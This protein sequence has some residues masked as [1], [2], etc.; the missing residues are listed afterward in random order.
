MYFDIFRK[1]L[2]LFCGIALFALAVTIMIKANMGLSP[3]D[4]FHQG[5]S[6]KLNITF[7][8]A[9]ILVGLGIVIVNAILGERIGWGTICS[10]YFVGRGVDILMPLEVIPQ[11]TSILSGLVMLSVGMILLG[12]GS[13]FYLSA[14]LGSGPREGLMIALIKRTNKSVVAIRTI[15]EV[16]A[17]A[18]GLVFGGN[19]GIGTLYLVFT[20]GF[21]V[22][23]VYK[24]CRFNVEEFTHRFVDEDIVWIKNRL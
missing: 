21:F 22:Q 18:L 20:T 8:K 16:S 1:A 11:G 10:M 3:W 6:M 12:F 4:V 19:V 14:G 24:F 23:C 15:L 17:L 2:R 9:S 13:Y 5:L 7:G